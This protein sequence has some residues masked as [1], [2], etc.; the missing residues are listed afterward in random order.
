MTVIE[1][2]LCRIVADVLG[3]EA[4]GPRDGFF[5]VGGD[6]VLALQVVARAREAGL[7]LSVRDLFDHQTPSAL[8]A[9]TGDRPS[10]VS[11]P[12][13]LPTFTADELADFE[14]TDVG[15]STDAGWET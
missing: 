14:D 5:E 1:A 11:A 6:S 7:V 9:V 4:V 13:P 8:A 3:L 12:E 2:T 15:E 10:S